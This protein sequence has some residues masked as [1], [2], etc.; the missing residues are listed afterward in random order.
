MKAGLF[1]S[2]FN[3]RKSVLRTL[4]MNSS[5]ASISFTR[6]PPRVK[7]EV[8]YVSKSPHEMFSVLCS[9]L[10]AFERKVN[11]L[12]NYIHTYIYT[13]T[14]YINSPKKIDSEKRIDRRNS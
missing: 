2:R 5:I 3:S 11:A 10:Y 6:F 13:Y 9:C 12:F 7:I 14:Q 4:R 1:P 8:L